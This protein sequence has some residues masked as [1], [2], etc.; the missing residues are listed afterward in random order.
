[1]STPEPPG[2]PGLR[3]SEPIRSFCVR[4]RMRI[5]AMSYVWPLFGAAQSRGTATD[6]HS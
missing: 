4:D 3:T 5:I 2:P 1:M 6:A